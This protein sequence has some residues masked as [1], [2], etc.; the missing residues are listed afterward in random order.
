MK[1]DLETITIEIA[2]ILKE[3]GVLQSFVFGSY[4]RNEANAESDLDLLVEFG[5]RKSLLDVIHIKHQLE[6]KT[7]ISVD[8]FT[9]AAIYPALREYIDQDKVRIL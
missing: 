7:G 4:A 3:A 9:D 2:P 1:K 6:D 5:S 8:L